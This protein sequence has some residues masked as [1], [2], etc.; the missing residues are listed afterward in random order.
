MVSDRDVTM[1][2]SGDLHVQRE[3]PESIFAFTAGYLREA[4]L[5]FGNLEA[6]VTDRGKPTE[7][8]G[9]GGATFKS[10][11]RMFPAYTHA[12]LDA[13]GLANNHSMNY[14][15]DGLLR[16][17]E[18]LEAAG[19]AHAGGGNNISMAREPAVVDRKG[20]RIAFL[21]YSSVFVP[22]F[23]AREDRGGIPTVRV[24]TAY[25]PQ[26]RLAEV[27]GS[28][29]IIRT[30]P[31]PADA[32]AMWEDVQKARQAADVVVISWHWGLSPASGG[33]GQIVSYQEEM[34]RAAIDAGADIVLGHHPHVLQAIEVYKGRPIF[35]FMGNF[36]FDL[37]RGR[38]QTTA[39]ARCLIRDGAIK[40]IAFL[41]AFI[42]ENA[43]PA[44]ADTTKGSAIVEHVQAVSAKYGTSFTVRDQDVVINL[45]RRN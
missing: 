21:S 18:L 45:D 14:G 5:F 30:F 17:I 32:A 16:T 24:S 8:K 1:V 44:L 29:P 19:I 33:V 35:Y 34:A 6:A 38:A 9:A 10:E 20:N 11:E 7:A 23:A 42:N 43:Q 37:F 13:V 12:G 39:L 31:D 2:L 41:P 3:D 27:P 36:A 25:E 28:P 4:D 22:P 15:T 40:E 26:A